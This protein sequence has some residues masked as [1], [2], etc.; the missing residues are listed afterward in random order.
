MLEDFYIL[1][2]KDYISKVLPYDEAI[3]GYAVK[4]KYHTDMTS[5]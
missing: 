1:F 4:S 2:R 3:R 5:C